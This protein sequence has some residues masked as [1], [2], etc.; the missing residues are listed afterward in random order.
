[1][2]L[3]TASYQAAAIYLVNADLVD[4]RELHLLLEV[5]AHNPSNR[6]KNL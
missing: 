3:T 6:M 5:L 4:I 1:M 2:P